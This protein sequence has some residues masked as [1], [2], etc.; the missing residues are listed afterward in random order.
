MSQQRSCCCNPEQEFGLACLHSDKL[1]PNSESI[2]RRKDYQ[3]GWNP[4]TFSRKYDPYN[5]YRTGLKP[6]GTP[7]YQSQGMNDWGSVQSYVPQGYRQ[8]DRGTID[9]P[10]TTGQGCMLCHGSLIMSFKASRYTRGGAVG[11][12][13]TSCQ[14]TPGCE[15]LVTRYSAT[16]TSRPAEQTMHVLYLAVKDVWYFERGPSGIPYSW[17]D[18]TTPPSFLPKTNDPNTGKMTAFTENQR[19]GKRNS[20]SPLVSCRFTPGF[21]PPIPTDAD[22]LCHPNLTACTN[23]G[24]VFFEGGSGVEMQKAYNTINGPGSENR[25]PELANYCRRSGDSPIEPNCAYQNYVCSQLE[26]NT[27]PWAEPEQLRSP[28]YGIYQPGFSSWQMYQMRKDP[29]LRHLGDTVT[30]GNGLR[31]F[32]SPGE[33]L[34]EQGDIPSNTDLYTS[35]YGSLMGTLYRARIWVKA[36]KYVGS[37]Y[38]FPCNDSSG[39][40]V[41]YHP[42]ATNDRMQKPWAAGGY[43]DMTKTCAS[44]PAILIY[45][46][47]GV[48]VYSSDLRDEYLKGSI[49]A[50]M[51]DNLSDF[52]EGNF[53][54]GVVDGIDSTQ[55]YYECFVLPQIEK[56][57]GETGRFVAK[58]WREDQVE[59]YSTLEAEFKAIA[60]EASAGDADFPAAQE[61]VQGI[62]LPN[63]IKNY[64]VPREVTDDDGNTFITENE[65]LPVQKYGQEFLT[66]MINRAAPKETPVG[67]SADLLT[68]MSHY[69]AS[70]FDGSNFEID[71]YDPWHPENGGTNVPDS[72]DNWPRLGTDRQSTFPIVYGLPDGVTEQFAFRYPIRDAYVKAYP[73][74]GFE[75][76][77]V[78]RRWVPEWEEKLFESWY[79]NNPIYVHACS[80]GWSF[81]G[82]GN[83]HTPRFVGASQ[84]GIGNIA[85]QS[86][87]WATQLY[88]LDKLDSIHQLERNLAPYSF[89]AAKIPYPWVREEQRWTGLANYSICDGFPN[90]VW[91]QNTP[92]GAGT[93]WNISAQAR[94]RGSRT[95][96]KTIDDICAPPGCLQYCGST[97][98][99]DDAFPCCCTAL[100]QQAPPGLGGQGVCNCR[101]YETASGAILRNCCDVRSSPYNGRRA[102]GGRLIGKATAAI[103]TAQPTSVGN[104]SSKLEIDSWNRNH[105]ETKMDDSS[106]YGIRCSES[107]GCPIGYKCCCPAGC[108]GDCFCIP[109]SNDCETPPCASQF[110]FNTPCCQTFG[111]CCYEEDGE[112]KCIDNVTEEQCI[113]RKSLGGF[114]GI[115]N[116][117]SECSVGQCPTTTV[118]GACFYTD[119]LLDH[120]MC[121]QTTQHACAGLSGEFH[122]NQKCSEFPEKK[123]TGYEDVSGR[124]GDR[125]SFAGDRTC[126]RFGYSVN[127]CTEEIDEDT[128]EFV[129]T[130]EVKCISDCDTRAGASRIVSS[131]ESCGELGHC[132]TKDGYCRPNVTEADCFGTWSPG[133]ECDAESCINTG[134][135]DSDYDKDLIYERKSDDKGF[136]QSTPDRRGPFR[137]LS[138]GNG[139]TDVPPSIGDVDGNRGV[140][141][142]SFPDS[143]SSCQG[144]AGFGPVTDLCVVGY[145]DRFNLAG[146]Y[147]PIGVVTSP[148][149]PLTG[150]KV[151][152]NNSL[153]HGCVTRSVQVTKIGFRH[154]VFTS[155]QDTSGTHANTRCPLNLT[156]YSGNDRCCDGICNPSYFSTVNCYLPKDSRSVI[157]DSINTMEVTVYPYK[158]RCQQVRDSAGF[159]VCGILA[160]QLNPSET[161]DYAVGVAGITDFL[162]CHEIRK[163][164]AGSTIRYQQTC[165]SGPEICEEGTCIGGGPGISVEVEAYDGGDTAITFDLNFS[166]GA[167]TH[168]GGFCPSLTGNLKRAFS[169]PFPGA[170][171]TIHHIY[172]PVYGVGYIPKLHCHGAGIEK[173]LN[174]VPRQV[175]AGTLADCAEFYN[176]KLLEDVDRF[177]APPPYEELIFHDYGGLTQG[178]TERWMCE[179]D[180]EDS[181]A[182]WF[183]GASAEYVDAFFNDSKNP[184]EFWIKKQF[185]ELQS[186]RLFGVG[187]YNIPGSFEGGRGHTLTIPETGGVTYPAG[188]DFAGTMV[189]SFGSTSEFQRFDETYGS[190]NLQ[191]TFESAVP[192]QPVT[193][194]IG[195]NSEFRHKFVAQPSFNIN[196]D[197]DFSGCQPEDITTDGCPPVTD[198]ETGANGQCAYSSIGFLNGRG[199]T[200]S[201]VENGLTGDYNGKVYEFCSYLGVNAL[202][203]GSPNELGGQL[204]P[205]FFLPDEEVPLYSGVRGPLVLY[206]RNEEGE[207]QYDM[208]VTLKRFDVIEDNQCGLCYNEEGDLI[209]DSSGNADLRTKDACLE[210]L[211]DGTPTTSNQFFPNVSGITNGGALGCCSHLT[212]DPLMLYEDDPDPDNPPGSPSISPCNR[213]QE[214]GD[215]IHDNPARTFGNGD[216]SCE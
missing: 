124:I 24:N 93:Y 160:Q 19:L 194:P 91:A 118:R 216:C 111:S 117:D 18:A 64:L 13:P 88:Q 50:N 161:K 155:L 142:A 128:G 203:E 98:D 82:M 27:H 31:V 46:C 6:L 72:E 204:K 191:L 2:Y 181:N 58:D 215:G 211:P 68:E 80:G 145:S 85:D 86:C 209:T 132:C 56:A 33:A 30:Y 200:Y 165:T 84:G 157:H 120:Q 212:E 79:K 52:Y 139:G 89:T 74:V 148:P 113:A 36:D 8:G 190:E 102:E 205:I 187:C 178:D 167:N 11:D 210:P 144:F 7:D 99:C 103:S 21:F 38:R 41:A 146:K 66:F 69:Q 75:N 133:S 57:L 162:T 55:G 129:R 71:F 163:N 3:A 175:P 81:S 154:V 150:C 26:S 174:N 67:E 195:G 62:P 136:P 199:L 206:A 10:E 107:G 70:R 116:K 182:N 141:P 125:P 40:T 90:F 60:A 104:K 208:R 35:A 65:L 197:S 198:T 59:K 48:P 14:F 105:P 96:C 147:N 131:C 5:T 37:D 168:R 188:G 172:A 97:D 15:T 23:P 123:T 127:C 45:T 193:N 112:L 185:P 192:N 61:F 63:S 4:Y 32:R 138:D 17:M 34:T 119:K 25:S 77:A 122:A 196:K 153:S 166:G 114:D 78:W 76:D 159:W 108:D 140:P 54:E 49:P 22:Y 20:P 207:D 106:F 92:D 180:L 42:P 184:N 169:I 130:C 143:C 137:S 29:A 110:D 51:V 189:L 28:C 101:G 1:N 126:G 213:W 201:N 173:R 164:F 156:G 152:S 109:E 214:K 16:V 202:D 43:S 95:A 121:R 179:S 12:D 94:N 158:L 47:S 87:R 83:K 73:G 186:I 135:F 171:N 53:T 115:F 177:V 176:D 44:G 170:S 134:V 149:T 151:A 39:R 183:K 9:T 100:E